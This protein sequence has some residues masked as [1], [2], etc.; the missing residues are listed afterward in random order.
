VPAVL[1]TFV[2]LHVPAERARRPSYHAFVPGTFKV[3]SLV[4]EKAEYDLSPMNLLPRSINPAAAFRAF[5]KQFGITLSNAMGSLREPGVSVEAICAQ[6][7]S[8]STTERPPNAEA[9]D[10]RP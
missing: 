3:N 8:V 2:V 9:F 10:G 1:F 7:L 6:D 5:S 4:R